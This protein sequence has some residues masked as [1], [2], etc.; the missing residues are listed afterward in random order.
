MLEE[1]IQYKII[2]DS[3]VCN[4]LLLP[5][6]NPKADII[7]LKKKEKRKTGLLL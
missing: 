2:I 5:T 3:I 1:N 6:T 7:D 4:G